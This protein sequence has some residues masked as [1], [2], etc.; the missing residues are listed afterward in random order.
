MVYNCDGLKYFIY[1][2]TINSKYYLEIPEDIRKLIWKYAHNY[3]Y[4][5]CYICDKVL[6]NLELNILNNIET[7]NFSII[8]GISRC[9]TCQ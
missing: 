4:I 5:Q 6:I 1:N 9:S 7:E 2:T 8:N 3:L